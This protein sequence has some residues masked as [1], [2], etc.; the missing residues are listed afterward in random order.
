MQH[1]ASWGFIVMC[2]NIAVAPFQGGG[3]SHTVSIV[4]TFAALQLCQ[5]KHQ[6]DVRSVGPKC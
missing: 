6:V 1:L 5:R 2:P 4:V 3:V